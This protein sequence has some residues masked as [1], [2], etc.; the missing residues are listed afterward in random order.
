M[1]K[2]KRNILPDIL[3]GLGIFL[4]V[5]G[6]ATGGVADCLSSFTVFICRFSLWLP[7]TFM[8]D[9]TEQEIVQRLL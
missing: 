7:D 4:V 9:I 2:E 6:H 5:L 8:E 3:K 1:Q